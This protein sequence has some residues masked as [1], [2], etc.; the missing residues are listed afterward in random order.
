MKNT[1]LVFLIVGADVY[2]QARETQNSMELFY[3][4]TKLWKEKKN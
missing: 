1:Y 4:S 3:K 2:L